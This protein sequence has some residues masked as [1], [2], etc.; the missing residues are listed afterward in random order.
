MAFLTQDMVAIASHGL[1]KVA[2]AGAP[3]ITAI[4]P[5]SGKLGTRVR[6]T[7]SGFGTSGYAFIGGSI[8][9][10][11]SHTTTAIEG[12]ISYGLASGTHDV[13]VYNSSSALTGRNQN[14]F[15]ATTESGNPAR[16]N[17][18]AAIKWNLEQILVANGYSVNVRR[19]YD[20]PRNMA[21]MSEYPAINLI[22]GVEDMTSEHIMGNQQ[23]YD[24]AITA[25]FDCFLHNVNDPI[26]EQDKLLADVQKIFGN[27]H[28][29]TG[30]DNV[31]TAFVCHYMGAEPFG[32]E[33][34]KPNSG[35][36]ITFKFYYRIK[37]KDPWSIA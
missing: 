24:N 6:I 16:T 36:S 20:P 2:T 29:V 3:N 31:R 27:N 15:T 14:L 13:V 25:T 21:K 7:G 18:R 35:I 5:A 17:L 23:L 19:V 37:V 9:S 30:E 1:F 11:I 8:L 34:E 32:T 26:A 33:T 12:T 4:S 22:W 10:I 28:P